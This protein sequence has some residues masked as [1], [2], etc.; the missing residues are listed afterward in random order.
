M[1]KV[2]VIGIGRLGICFSLTLEKCGYQVLGVDINEKYVSSIN[3][4][5]LVSDEQGV[6]EHLLKSTNFRA[7]TNIKAALD[8]SDVLYVVVATPSLPDGKY[9]HSQVDSVVNKLLT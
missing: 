8:Y 4:K 5:T 3:N 7:S 2:S 1:K 9:D 6:E